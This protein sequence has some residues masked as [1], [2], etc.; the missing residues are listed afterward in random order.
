MPSLKPVSEG[1]P[2]PAAML[3]QLKG[4]GPEFYG[5]TLV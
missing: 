2:T 5:N 4:M 1:C 3:A